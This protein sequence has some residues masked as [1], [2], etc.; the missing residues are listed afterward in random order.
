MN[1]T[2]LKQK[3]SLIIFGIFLSVVFLEVALRMAGAVFLYLQERDNH[4]SFDHNEYRILC[5]GESTTALG[6]EDSYPS[7]LEAMLNAQAGT[8]RFTVINEGIIS[9]TSNYILEHIEQNLDRYKPQ[10]A[11]VM[12]GINDRAFLHD[13]HRSLWGENIKSY[14]EDFRVY[15]LGHLL[16]EHI[17]HR[18]RE[19]NA[20]AGVADV[21]SYDGNNQYEEDFLKMVII[22]S[23]EKFHEN[24]SDKKYLTQASLACIELAR[25]YRLQGSFRK[26]R[27]ILAQATAFDPDQSYL[28][29]EWGDF[30]LA[31]DQGA[32]ALQAFKAAL[33]LDP[34]NSDILLGLAHAYYQ[35][36][37]DEAFILYAGYLQV[38][39]R[40]YWG[41]I[42]LA[43]WLR[44]NKHY[45]QAQGYLS[46]AMEVLSNFDQA[47]V[48]FGQILDDQAQYRR[49]EAFYLKEIS[50]HPKSLLLCQALGQFYQK[51]GRNDL[52]AGYFQ[53]AAGLQM[54][55]YCPATLV[56]YS[57]LLDKILSRHI[58]A[59]VMQYP[60]RDIDPLKNYLGRKN[61]VIFVEN[62]KNFKQALSKEGFWH[63]FKDNFAYDFGHCT[64]AGNELIARHLKEVILN[65]I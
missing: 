19:I 6:G 16:Y 57:L 4:L 39:P 11:I 52:A 2:S 46:R 20:P 26:A 10:M 32:L 1:K 60:L 62:K 35:E 64:R 38:K 34:K 12:M 5:L 65:K 25:R 42:E 61:G 13:F 63:Y 8:K 17:T 44:E 33:A 55:E 31:Q 21:A 36:H 50:L 56:N 40:D 18:I 41:Y 48:D 14:L 43:R 58:K 15:K 54:P 37:N 3:L 28:Y 23:L 45:E 27:E 51:Q 59:V 47:Y 30:Y 53:K 9:T 24:M 29:Q 22:K 7:Q 49:E